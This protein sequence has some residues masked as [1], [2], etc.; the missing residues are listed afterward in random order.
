MTGQG[1]FFRGCQKG[2]TL[3]ELMF[4]IAVLVVLL[5]V[6][7]PSFLGTIQENRAVSTAND[8][9]Y[10]LKMTRSAAVEKARVFRFCPRDPDHATDCGS[11]WADGWQILDVD[12]DE[13]VAEV[14]APSNVTVSVLDSGGSAITQIDFTATGTVDGGAISLEVQSG[15]KS[16]WVCVRGVGNSRV[17]EE[18]CS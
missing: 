2:L 15:D 1:N 14:N 18:A 12:D 4:T 9:L 7:V 11:D 6:G 16:R 8:L 10:H 13:L 5:G 17:E 3:L